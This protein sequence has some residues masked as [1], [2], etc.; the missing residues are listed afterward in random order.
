MN[1][2]LIPTGD[3]PPNN[4]NVVVEIPISG[5][6]VKYEVDKRRARMFVDRVLHTPMRYPAN[7]GYVPRTSSR[8]GDPLER[9]S[10]PGHRSSPA[11]PSSAADRR[12][13]TSRTS[14]A[15]TRSSSASPSTRSFHIIRMSAIG[16]N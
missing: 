5:E 11:A 7:Y 16:R 12:H 13:A 6:P 10:S 2:D 9:W 14:L 8:D 4:V 15:M 3:D 1:I